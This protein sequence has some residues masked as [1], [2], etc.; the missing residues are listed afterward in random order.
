L[1][2]QLRCS[3]SEVP[4]PGEVTYPGQVPQKD[5]VE[6]PSSLEDPTLPKVEGVGTQVSRD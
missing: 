6:K 4:E 2:G 1:E 3:H 5:A